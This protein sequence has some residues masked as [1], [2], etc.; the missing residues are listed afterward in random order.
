MGAGNAGSENWSDSA[1]ILQ[2]ESTGFPDGIHMGRERRKEG[3]RDVYHKHVEV[4]RCINV[5]YLR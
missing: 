1:Y 2:V 3:I 4:P 5:M